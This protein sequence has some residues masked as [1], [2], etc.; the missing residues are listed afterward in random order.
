MM[1]SMEEIPPSAELARLLT[2]FDQAGGV[3]DFALFTLPHGE[4]IGLSH[5]QEAAIGT[6]RAVER[7]RRDWQKRQRVKRSRQ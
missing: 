1:M 6:I 3:V 7:K 2:E 5:H 4:A